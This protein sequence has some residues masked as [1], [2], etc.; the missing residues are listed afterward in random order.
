MPKRLVSHRSGLF[1]S[2]WHHSSSLFVVVD[3]SK[4]IVDSTLVK[5][6]NK[7][8]TYLGP[9]TPLRASFGP[10]ACPSPSSPLIGGHCG[11]VAPVMSVSGHETHLT[12]LAL[13][14]VAVRRS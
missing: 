2:W 6:I 5:R 12:C 1:S 11:D 7:K 3:K 14:V 9:N 13:L 8:K 10:T 4:Y